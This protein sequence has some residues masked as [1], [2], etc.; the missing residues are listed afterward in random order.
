MNASLSMKKREEL[1]FSSYST[2]RKEG[3]VKGEYLV[4]LPD[5]RETFGWTTV[6]KELTTNF[7]SEPVIV[8]LLPEP[9]VWLILE[10]LCYANLLHQ[11]H[12]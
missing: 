6:F 8:L 1:H 2:S 10:G 5:Q 9:P 3:S 7:A 12:I 4:H 11:L